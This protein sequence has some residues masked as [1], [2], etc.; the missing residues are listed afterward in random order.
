MMKKTYLAMAVTSMVMLSAC[1]STKLSDVG[2]GAPMPAGTQQAISEQRA[3]NDFKRQ[4]VKVIFSTFGA[5]E[6]V[7]AT[8]YAPVWGNSQNAVREAYRVAEL[9][10]KKSLND[11]INS[12]SIRSST[13][14]KMISRNLEKA[15]DNKSNNIATNR[16]RDEVSA[17]TEDTEVASGDVNTE[18]NTATR[19]DALNIASR[20]N[21]EISSKAQGILSGLRLVEGEVI[22][23][24]K[25]V[26]VVYRWD[27]KNQEIRQQIR[28]M[29][30][31]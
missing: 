6:A 1:S 3:V 2:S 15:R 4:G 5:F 22:N 24:G 10:A 26:R 8:G 31:Q 12:E 14:V 29:M 21:T 13:S 20:V 19:N 30:M 23:D 27:V 9:E 16:N 17:V 25:N 28:R 18:R 7:E 11:F